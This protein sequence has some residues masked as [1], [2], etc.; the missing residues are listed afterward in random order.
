MT[1]IEVI[2]HRGLEPT[3]PDFNPE[4]S[5]ESFKDQLNRGFGIEF[6]PNF[7]K[8]G[9]VIWHDSTLSRLSQGKDERAFKDLT[10]ADLSQIRFWNKTHT[11]E[12]RIPTFNEV[13]ELIRKSPSRINALHFK[14]KFQNPQDT[15]TLI[16]HMQRN[17]DVLKR[18]LVF[19]IKPEIAQLLL[20]TF[21]DLQLAP[22]VA[23]KH[24]VKRYNSVVGE[25]LIET[26]GVEKM[27]KNGVFGKNPWVWLDEW[28]L[29]DENEGTKN[30]YNKEVFMQMRKAGARIA[31]VTPE[32]HGT[33]PGLYG[34]E[35]HPDSRDQKTLFKRIKEI[36]DL[37][38]DAICTD[39][40]EEV[41]R[42]ING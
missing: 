1:S 37:K 8:D 19:D 2:T 23:H 4:S 38:P 30:I 3:K 13:M 21:P 32:L 39:Y 41:F 11:T 27:L 42:L 16:A 17:S 33:S 31:L 20:A 34:G 36:L 12:G 10:I 18:I 15:E 24:D 40:P 35:S 28:D 29:V 5:Y 9:I 22:S 14:G 26:S 6:D 7:A 25:A